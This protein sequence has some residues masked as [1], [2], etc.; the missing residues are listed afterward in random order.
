MK[1]LVKN[2]GRSVSTW[3]RLLPGLMALF[4][5]MANS[6]MAMDVKGPGVWLSNE[7]QLALSK[8][9]KEQLRQNLQQITGLTELQFLENGQLQLGSVSESSESGDGSAA[10]RQILQR[11]I[12]SGYVFFIEDHSDSPDV[13]FGQLDEGT[14][15]E[16]ESASRKFLIWRVRLD[17]DDFRKMSAPRQVRESFSVGF[18]VLHEL[19]HGLGHRDA[20]ILTEVG[21]C[22]EQVNKARLELSLPTRDQYFAAQQKITGNFFTYR[23]KFRDHSRRRDEYLFFMAPFGSNVAEVTEGVVNVRKPVR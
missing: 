2:S 17:F 6:A 20:Q 21:E 22:E 5:G 13:N 7:K 16:D 10:A 15:Y 8:S 23:L 3:A 19:L 12:D 9:Q 11:A 18:T 1:T 4:L 14:L